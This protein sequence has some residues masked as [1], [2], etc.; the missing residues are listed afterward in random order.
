MGAEFQCVRYKPSSKQTVKKLWKRDVEDDLY[1][2]GHS[3]SGSI[4]MLGTDIQWRD[5]K[6][7]TLAECE[8]F[9]M[10]NHEK[11]QPP[12]AV[13]YADGWVVGGWCSS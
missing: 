3:Y 10:D 2:N 1:D 12:L 13:G 11:W 9:L 8:K 4:G 6:F 7:Q 5:E